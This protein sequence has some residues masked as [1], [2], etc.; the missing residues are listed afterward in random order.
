[1]WF[2]IYIGKGRE[3]Y[4]DYFAFLNFEDTCK[5]RAEKLKTLKFKF[6][7]FRRFRV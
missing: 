6:S 3:E 1:M 4:L 2:E 7:N 5:G